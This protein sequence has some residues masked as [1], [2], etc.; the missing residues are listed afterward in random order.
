MEA[1][2][3]AKKFVVKMTQNFV[4]GAER[5]WGVRLGS[6]NTVVQNPNSRTFGLGAFHQ[7]LRAVLKLVFDSFRD[8]RWV[9]NGLKIQGFVPYKISG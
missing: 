2:E 7:R 1:S 9:E 4:E 3:A 5:N 8:L 6:F